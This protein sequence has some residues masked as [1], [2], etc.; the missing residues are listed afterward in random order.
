M[1]AIPGVVSSVGREITQNQAR[2]KAHV[3]APFY[4]L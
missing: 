4:A 2:H 1:V 3:P